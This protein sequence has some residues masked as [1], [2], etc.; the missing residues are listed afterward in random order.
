MEEEEVG[1]ALCTSHGI[2]CNLTVHLQKHENEKYTV[3]TCFRSPVSGMIGSVAGSWLGRRR[4][5][6]TTTTSSPDIDS[7]D[8]IKNEALTCQLGCV[9]H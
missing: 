5:I 6:E 8:S 7:I 3:Q 4:Q 2:S 9:Q 1:F